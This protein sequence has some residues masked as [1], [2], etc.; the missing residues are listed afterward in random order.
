MRIYLR[1]LAFT[2]PSAWL[3]PQYF[4]LILLHTVFRVVNFGALVPVLRILFGRIEDVPVVDK[5]PDFSLTSDYF[6]DTFYYYL[7]NTIL[8]EGKIEALYLVV[9][10]L[11]ASV[12]LSNLFLYFATVLQARIRV[13]SV[14]DMRKA[15]FD[16]VSRLHMG[17]FTEQRKGDILTRI[18]TDIQQIELTVVNTIRVILK[19]PLLIIAFF[20]T[21]F[22]ISP[23]LTLYTM[24][25][26]PI[27]GGIISYIARK[28]KR[29]AR[30]SQQ[31]IG[32]M[33][34]IVEESLGA[35]RVIKAF[36]ARKYITGKFDKEVDIYGRQNFRIAAGSN[37][38]SPLSE[39]LGVGFIAAILLIG[40]HM[41]LSEQT[42]LDAANFLFFLIIFSQILTPAKAISNAFSN[43]QKGIASG[44]RIFELMDVD[45]AIKDKPGA[46]KMTSFEKGITFERV[47]FSYQDKQV[48]KKVSFE[49]PKGKVVALVGPSGGGKSTIASLLPRFYDVKEGTIR[50][51]DLPI[52][53]YKIA[54]LRSHMGIVTQESILFNDT[55]F[56]N[57]AFGKEEAT[58]DE[59]EAAAKLANA[60]DFILN[61]E[62]GY[63]TVVGD[64][65]MKLSGGQRQRISIARALLKN[66]QILIL[67]E[68]T[69][70]LDSESEKLVQEAI[71]QLMQNR[72]A[73]VI[74]HRLSTVQHA[75]IIIVIKDG[76]IAE[77][78][79]HESLMNKKGLYHRLIQMQ[80]L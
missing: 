17:F 73:L 72:T 52:D 58:F 78:G 49:I 15:V 22:S 66:P 11:V 30:K 55:I 9:Y 41:I 60:H 6:I 26:I 69:S 61:L 79:N 16:H 80:S 18:T 46:K 3:I 53:D 59:V 47:S 24:L 28:L 4:V 34:S 29:R 13:N 56:R 37:L 33:T 7:G 67:D 76:E 2:K 39:F 1:I 27:S 57:I 51:D 14:T 65:G 50:L 21:L 38:V 25:L 71:Y 12:L 75:D 5:L 40:G 48:L 44:E 64:Q 35:M 36:S 77:Q 10:V 23:Q 42:E 74:A 68:A 54:D 43:I 62:E 8:S 31:A 70:A 32:R 63:D 19:E 45:I 20:I